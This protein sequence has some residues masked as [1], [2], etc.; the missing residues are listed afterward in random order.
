MHDDQ[1]ELRLSQVNIQEEIRQQEN[2]ESRWR[3]FLGQM[4]RAKCIDI[5]NNMNSSQYIE[6]GT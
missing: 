3:I 5:E 4:T 2:S 6:L 1:K